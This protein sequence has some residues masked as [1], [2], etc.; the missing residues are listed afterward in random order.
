MAFSPDNSLSVPFSLGS[1][2]DCR[3]FVCF[4][5]L[6]H[7]R[8]YHGGLQHRQRRPRLLLGLRPS[9]SP[10]FADGS[11]HFMR[12]FARSG[13][14][15]REGRER[16]EGP[17]W[18][19]VSMDRLSSL[20]GEPFVSIPFLPFSLPRSAFLPSFVMSP[21]G[22]GRGA[23][24]RIFPAAAC[25]ARPRESRRRSVACPDMIDAA[26]AAAAG[27]RL[28]KMDGRLACAEPPPH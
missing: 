5:A 20:S 11:R 15:G 9:A 21:S 22:R 8:P 1:P 19:I 4:C 27:D 10:F 17:L 28:S 12:A 13:A 24:W 26:A 2:F 18:S 14:R 3:I 16:A 25:A 6:R 23:T 7:A